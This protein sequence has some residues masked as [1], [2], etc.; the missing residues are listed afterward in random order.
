MVMALERGEREGVGQFGGRCEE[1]I[2]RGLDLYRC[3]C[4]C[5]AASSEGLPYKVLL[6]IV[7]TRK[8]CSL[9]VR[10]I[11]KRWTMLK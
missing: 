1:G 9:F 3:R 5:I 11:K 7:I 4:N 10:V 6:A 2:N 8:D